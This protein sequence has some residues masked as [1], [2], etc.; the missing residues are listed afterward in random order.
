MTHDQKV[1][2]ARN[3]TFATFCLLGLIA[4]CWAVSYPHPGVAPAFLWLTASVC[5]F[6]FVWRLSCMFDALRHEPKPKGEKP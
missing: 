4:S 3:A 5:G 2:V 6:G 1:E